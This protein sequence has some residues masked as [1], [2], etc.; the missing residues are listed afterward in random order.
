MKAVNTLIAILGVV[1]LFALW[2]GGIV[3]VSY[4]AAWLLGVEPTHRVSLPLAALGAIIASALHMIIN[5]LNE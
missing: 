3:A 5:A 2:F 4:G 1:V